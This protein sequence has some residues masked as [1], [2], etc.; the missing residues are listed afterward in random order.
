VGGVVWILL[1]A[2]GAGKGTQSS[3]LAEN[4]GWAHVST[5]DLLRAHRRD[6]TPL[7]LAAEAHL[8]AGTLVPDETILAMVAERL[9]AADAADGVVADGFPRTLAQAEAVDELAKTT[10]RHPPRA[11]LL[12]V[13]DAVVMER[14]TG[15]WV[16]PSCGATYHVPLRPPIRAGICDACGQALAQRD[17]DT[18]ATVARR[19]SVYRQET[20]PVVDYYRSAGRL[21]SVPAEDRAEAVAERVRRVVETALE[22]DSSPRRRE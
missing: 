10:G 15:R 16:C 5:G 2:P 20:Q 7:G 14:L 4:M 6:G 3:T 13:S 8:R 18:P 21:A 9:A 1:G 22:A 11:L 12:E 19:L 17:D